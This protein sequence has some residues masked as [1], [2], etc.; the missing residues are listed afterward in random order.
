MSQPDSPQLLDVLLLDRYMAGELSPDERADVD[1]WLAR[2]LAHVSRLETLRSLGQAP[3]GAASLDME[4]AWARVSSSMAHGLAVQTPAPAARMWDVRRGVTRV[5]PRGALR[6]VA[7]YMIAGAALA[8]VIGGVRVGM[9]HLGSRGRVAMSTYVTANGQRANITLPDGSTVALGVASRLDVPGD[10]LAGHHTVR[11][12]GE[13]LVAVAHHDGVPFTIVAGDATTRVLGTSFLV[14]H[15]A[16]DTTTIVAVRDGKVAVHASSV[17]SVVLT[18]ARMLEVGRGGS[19]RL[20]QADPAVFGF[21]TGVMALDGVPLQ[22]AIVELD[23]WYDADI[24]L[25]DPTLATHRITGGFMAGSLAD[26]ASAL[27]WTFHM[28]VVRDGRVLTLYP[29]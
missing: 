7:F 22:D 15:Y 10:Y 6:R 1:A 20:Q 5:M 19:V 12:S 9:P 27:E 23:R 16:T 25:G 24:R 17:Q 21:A 26:V 11:L 14:R 18:A 29:R 13:A 2:D 28:R 4:Q 3:T 8:L